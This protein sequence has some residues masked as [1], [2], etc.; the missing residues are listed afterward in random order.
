MTDETTKIDEKPLKK[1]KRGLVKHHE[2]PFV[3]AAAESTKQGVRRIPNK[4]KDRMMIVSEHG[5]IIAP[6]G[7]HE[8]VE[9]DKTQFVKLY[10]NGVKAFQ[11]LT[12]AGT[13]VFEIIYR[14]V[15]EKPGR[16]IIY[17][18][19]HAIDQ[20]ITTIS[21]ST[22]YRGMRELIDKK[23]IA[24]SLSPSM[25]YLNIDYMFSGNR[26]AFI[27]EFRLKGTP[28]VS[29]KLEEAGQQRLID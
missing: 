8:V 29:E 21:E 22:F 13:K 16:D 24:E 27:K 1:G 6:A 28:S 9:V 17:I 10:I 3:K 20:D 18:S 23:F 5:E 7:F 12:N 14:S 15:Q 26:L 11:G 19:F 4:S 25:F 2:N